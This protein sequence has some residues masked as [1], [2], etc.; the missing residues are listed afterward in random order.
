MCA[1]KAGTSQV[2]LPPPLD[3]LFRP[4]EGAPNSATMTVELEGVPAL[5]F[6]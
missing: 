4:M 5:A 3:P 6:H 1:L 2:L